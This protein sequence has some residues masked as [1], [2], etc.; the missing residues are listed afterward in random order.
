MK[1]K[2]LS[3]FMAVLMVVLMLPTVAF[4]DETLQGDTD[5]S[6]TVVVYMTISEGQNGFY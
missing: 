3:I 4:A 2:I 6:G 5:N 1:K